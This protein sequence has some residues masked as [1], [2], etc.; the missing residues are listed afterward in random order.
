MANVNAPFGAAPCDRHGGGY[1]GADHVYYCDAAA[2]I[3]IGDIVKLG[4]ASDADGVHEVVAFSAGGSDPVGIVT[5]IV[6]DVASLPD[7]QNYKKS[8]DVVYLMVNDDPFVIFDM[9]FT[10][11]TPAAADMGLNADIVATAG[12]T[13]TGKSKFSLD[14]A[15]L[16]TTATLPIRVIGIEQKVGNELGASAVARCCFNLHAYRTDRVAV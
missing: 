4:T 12:S 2:A 15:T 11:G 14:V 10:N 3:Y 1:V 7:G 13:V 9:Q 8:A 16:A 6:R 5:G